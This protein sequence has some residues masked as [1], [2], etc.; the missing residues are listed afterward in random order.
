M[1]VL[2]SCSEGY[3]TLPEMYYFETSLLFKYWLY[4]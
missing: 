2:S 4:T 1:G 3:E